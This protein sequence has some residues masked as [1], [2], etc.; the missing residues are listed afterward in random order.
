MKKNNALEILKQ[1]ADKNPKLAEAY[2]IEKQNQDIANRCREFRNLINCTQSE[3][4]TRLGTS[5]STISRIERCENKDSLAILI[6][7]L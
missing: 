1:R 4:A 5:K 7:L 3:L 2:R 6:E